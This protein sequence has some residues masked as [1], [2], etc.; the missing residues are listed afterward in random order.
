[1]SG[2]AQSGMGSAEGGSL[3]LRCCNCQHRLS[4]VVHVFQRCMPRTGKQERSTIPPCLR[5][6]KAA[7]DPAALRV[8]S[9]TWRADDEGEAVLRAG[10]D[11]LH[12]H[13]GE[14]DRVLRRDVRRVGPR[15]RRRIRL[16][17]QLLRRG[18]VR[19]RRLVCRRLPLLFDA[20]LCVSCM[21]ALSLRLESLARVASW[22][23]RFAGDGT[24]AAEAPEP[25][26]L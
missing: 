14:A 23:C 18:R 5:A 9:Q 7:C 2:C 24:A 21:P 15:V 10:L 3:R 11:G 12:L 1:M 25:Q 16:H 6:C 17:Q 13:R 8:G 26:Q 19:R 4:N 22:R 20:A